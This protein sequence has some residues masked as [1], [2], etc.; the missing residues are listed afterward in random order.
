M[1]LAS[2]EMSFGG[3]PCEATLFDATNVGSVVI[4][5]NRVKANVFMTLSF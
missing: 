2:Q 5:K 4:F 3:I 1:L